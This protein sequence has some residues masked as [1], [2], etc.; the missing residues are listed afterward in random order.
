MTFCQQIGWLIVPLAIGWLDQRSGASPENVG[1]YAPGMWL[2]TAL[3]GLGL[4]FAWKLWQ[5][6]KS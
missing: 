1:G 3:S 5:S 2:Y 6:E 4:F